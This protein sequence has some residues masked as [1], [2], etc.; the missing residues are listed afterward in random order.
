M[1]PTFLG[2]EASKSAIYASQKALD[3]TGNNIANISS[4]GYTRQRIDQVSVNYIINSNRG[5]VN[6]RITLA[7]QGTN[8]LGISQTRDKQ[9][10][11]AFRKQS[12]E[13]GGFSR[14]SEMLTDIEDALQEFDVGDTGN[15]YGLRNAVS[16][17]YNALQDLSSDAGSPIYASTTADAFTQMTYTIRNMSTNLEETAEKYRGI[18]ED[19][20][21]DVNDYLE[22]IAALNK[23][24]KDAT[25]SFDYTEQYGP[26]ELLDQRNVLIDKLS[27]YG[28]VSVVNNSDGTTDVKFGD[29]YAVKGIEAE[30]INYH[31][32]NDGT[33][34]VK[35]QSDEAYVDAGNGILDSTVKILNGRGV[36][37]QNSTESSEKG[38]L[39]YRD[40]LDDFTARLVSVCNSTIPDEVDAAGNVISYKKLFGA[41]MPDGT[42]LN[43]MHV[44]ASN[45]QLSDQL[46][47]DVTYLLKNNGGDSDNTAVLNLV[48]KLSS[49]KYDFG[50]YSGTFEDFVNGYNTTL[51]GELSYVNS[52]YD[53]A[54]TAGNVIEKSR[55]SVVGVSETEETTNMLT[56]NR[57]FQAAA[58]MMTVMDDLL[59]VI[60][61]QMAV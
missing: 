38:I 53:A 42:V 55:E 7:G 26:N 39:Y 18:L 19:D 10:D 32:N 44:T 46:R 8:V 51:S 28:T 12:G 23:Q 58:R 40:K 1:R 21:F 6:N 15:G 11:N 33:V 45:I 48:A 59:D 25:A 34:S 57:A 56:Y 14:K 41:E 60:I 50:D 17:L 27:A 4:E 24:I 16:Q 3:I 31:E 22:K 35:W 47:E 2:F 20:V 37:M 49:E 5:Y 9:L 54:V 52:C 30:R 13:I 43:D 36:N 29:R 61:N